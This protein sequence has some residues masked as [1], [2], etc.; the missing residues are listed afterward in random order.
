MNKWIEFLIYSSHNKMIDKIEDTETINTNTE[1][2]TNN[3]IIVWLKK[4]GREFKNK[5]EKK[6]ELAPF[7]YLLIRLII[8]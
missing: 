2:M 3:R 1:E 6:R 4:K 8:S 5:K 7:N